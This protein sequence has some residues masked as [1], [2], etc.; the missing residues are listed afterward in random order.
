MT[1][2][3]FNLNTE[4]ARYASIVIHRAPETARH[5]D[6]Y[7]SE[8]SSP[9]R[10]ARQAQ[11]LSSKFKHVGGSH[12]DVG[13]TVLKRAN[14]Y[15]VQTAVESG[16]SMTAGINQD[17]TDYSYFVTVQLG[18]KGKE[19]Y[20]LVDTGAGSS[21]VM[22]ESCTDKACVMHNSFGPSDS[23]TFQDGAKTFSVS[24]G[25]GTVH[26]EL[27]SDTIALAGVSFRYQFGLASKT[28]EDFAHFAFDGILGLSMGLGASQNFLQALS[29]SKKL[30]KNVFGI[31]LNRASE[32]ENKGEIMFGSTNSALYTGDISYTPVGSKEGDWAI[33]IDEMSYDG[34]KADVGGVLAYIDTGTSFVFGPPDFVKKL[35]NNIPGSSSSDGLT[36]NVPCDTNKPLVFTFSGVDYEIS[37][38]DWVVGQDGNGKC[39]S[40][41]YGH[42]VVAG[43]WLLGDTF[44]KNVYAVFDKDDKKIGE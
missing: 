6:S 38:K 13:A 39:T 4:P 1:G 40:N 8:E 23:N 36:Y 29:D 21:W 11:W 9:E 26:G 20:M 17:G 30:D 44:L 25:S 10:A 7:Q 28:S 42:E 34:K 41:I 18:S 37:A 31:H 24:Y 2:W 15:K 16:K 33:Q 27:V 19:L 12:T 3:P 22:G 14:E 32:G 35:H 5:T 43:S